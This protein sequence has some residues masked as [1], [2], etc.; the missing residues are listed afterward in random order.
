MKLN[1]FSPLPPAKT[2]IARYT[3][4]LLPAL[5]SRAKVTLWTDQQE[6]D[7]CLSEWAAV[8]R[9][10]VEQMNWHEINEA[11]LCV[12]HI[13]NHHGFHFGPWQTNLRQPGL[14][15]LHD[16]RLHDFFAG[17]YRARWH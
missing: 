13:G 5:C 8:R 16:L 1:W 12:Y 4:D 2:G 14:V 11:E 10:D 7:P 15:V 9:Y 17:V 3:A 6:W